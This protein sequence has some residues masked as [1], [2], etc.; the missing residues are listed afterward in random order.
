MQRA[1][2]RRSW[3]FC[4]QQLVQVTPNNIVVEVPNKF[5]LDMPLSYEVSALLCC[6][7]WLT[8]AGLPMAPIAPKGFS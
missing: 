6:N 4:V 8:N 3:V 7:K 5:Y 2:T 1:A